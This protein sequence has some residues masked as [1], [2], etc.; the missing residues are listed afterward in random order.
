MN[1]NELYRLPGLPPVHSGLMKRLNQVIRRLGFSFELVRVPDGKKNMHTMEQR[2]NF[3]LLALCN[4]K[5]QVAGQWIELGC[6]TGQSAM[7]FQKLLDAY[8]PGERMILYD[9]FKAKYG[10]QADIRQELL[11]NFRQEGLGDPELIEGDFFDTVPAS[12]PEKLA[13]VHIDCGIGGQAGKHQE[14]VE[15]LL[16]HVYPRL[17]RGAMVLFM[18]YHDPLNTLRGQPINPGVK[19][20]CDVFFRDK[21]EQVYSLYGNHYSHGFMIKA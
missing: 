12:L 18:D 4:L 21:E 8:R 15:H 5:Y 9:L 7:V 3:Y 16:R 10:L 13:F 2:M 11:K 19:A 17:S 1:F 14:L 20:A 6:Y